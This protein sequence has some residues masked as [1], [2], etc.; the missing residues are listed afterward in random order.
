MLRNASLTELSGLF[1]SSVIRR[2]LTKY[3]Y[4]DQLNS[5]TIEDEN[6]R[7][8]IDVSGEPDWAY[9]DECMSAIMAESEAT[10]G[11]L[12]QADGGKHVID[13]SGWKEF[14]VGELFP[15]MVKSHVFHARQVVETDEGIPYVVRTKFNNGIKCRVQP[16]SD[17][18]PSPAGVITW[19]AENATFFYQ[20]EEFLSGRDIY[21]VDTRAYKAN[22]CVFLAACLQTVA[23]KYPYNY[24]LFPDLLK[25]ERIKLPV[26]ASGEP[27]WS[28]MNKYMQTIMEGA[29]SDLSTMQSI[30]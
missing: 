27:D 6:I 26:D 16:V 23:H 1:V 18:S 14:V 10:L 13:T 7:L 21:Y 22:A 20:T 12:R 19:G 2:S 9:M 5:K 11:S 25:E 15:S 17:V 29:K 24:G 8:P 4:S 28:Y 30:G 3:T